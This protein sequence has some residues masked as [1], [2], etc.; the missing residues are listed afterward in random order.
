[1]EHAESPS[2]IT[3]GLAANTSEDHASIHWGIV[4]SC[5][6]HGLIILIAVSLRFHAPLEQPF[7]AIDVAIISLNDLK[8]PTPRTQPKASPPVK[9][10]QPRVQQ[11][12]PKA[13]PQEPTLPPL[14]TNTASERLSESIGG[15]IESIVVPQQR[16]RQ[17]QTASPQQKT[18]ESPQDQTPLVKDLHLPSAA[19]QIA[20]PERLQPSSPVIVPQAKPVQPQRET[21]RPSEQ[22]P[23]TDQPAPPTQHA[24]K[25]VPQMKQAPAPPALQPVTPFKKVQRD[26]QP[27]ASV[28]EKT[29]EESIK[30]QIPTVPTV[31]PKPQIPLTS[32]RSKKPRKPP[33]PSSTPIAKTQAPSKTQPV[34]APPI[35]RAKTTPKSARTSVPKV[36]APEL[37]KIP[38]TPSE[39]VPAVPK[40]EKLSDSVKQLLGG[41]TIPKL[42]PVP[43]AKP[44]EAP[45]TP[46]AKSSTSPP[47][48][49]P[50]AI[51]QRIAKLTIPQVAPV[52]SI[53]QRLKLL[54]VQSS[55]SPG[56]KTAGP[57]PGENRYLAMVEDAIDQQW[58]APPLVQSTPTVILKFR[59]SRSGEI[60]NILIDESSG[61][62]HYDFA[63]LRAVRAVNPLPPFPKEIDKSYLDLLYR[64][65]KTE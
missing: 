47:P 60:S 50:S 19:P 64:F 11:S 62:E 38:T 20:R 22:E 17:R 26:P 46:T 40:R 5:L 52:E 18:S 39:K 37:A 14:P 29:L 1:M 51:D 45:T 59:I 48:R 35:S 55:S 13:R 8:S 12:Q 44:G 34:K 28:P 3:L 41:V 33:A 30:G 63:A 9:Q 6:L 2:L 15:A 54:A 61:H 10:A 53:K 16:E 27:P 56:G 58:V 7:R 32:K 43:P 36:A 23:P 65:Q 21:S 42:K 31:P 49:T 57:S 4:I 25:N 24:A